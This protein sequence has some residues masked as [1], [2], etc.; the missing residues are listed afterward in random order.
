MNQKRALPVWL[1]AAALAVMC[2]LPLPAAADGTEILGPPLGVDVQPG[3][4]MV[5]AGTG[6][7]VQPGSLDFIVPG[8]AV[9]EQ[10]LLYWSGLATS[11]AGGDDTIV[12]KGQ[13]I[14]GEPVGGPSPVGASLQRT[15]YRAEIT[16][17]ALVVPGDNSLEV[18][19]LSFD[20]GNDGAGIL[21]I[22]QE[23]AGSVRIHLRDGLDLAAPGEKTPYDMSVPV[24]FSVESATF[25]RLGSLALMVGGVADVGES[26]TLQVVVGCRTISLDDPLTGTDGAMWD[27]VRVP[28]LVPAGETRILV[29]LQPGSPG[30]GEEDAASFAWVA[31]AL[32]LS[33]PGGSIG[34]LV[35][36]DRN[37]DGIEDPGEPG[38]AGVKVRLA[39]AG[40]DG[41]FDTTDDLHLVKWTDEMGH[42]RFTGLPAGS[43]EVTV[44]ESTLPAGS[45]L[46]TDN[47]PLQIELD[48]EEDYDDADFG[49]LVP[50]D[51]GCS[52][53]Y[54]KNHPGAW[55]S[56]GLTPD[57]TVESVFEEADAYPAIAAATLAEALRFHGGPEAEGGARNLLRQA[58]AA[59]LNA[60]H[61]DIAFPRTGQ[62]VVDDVNQALASGDRH[63][64]LT[65]AGELDWDNNL[66]CSLDGRLEDHDWDDRIQI[67]RAPRLRF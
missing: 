55:A 64:M 59:L 15:S 47:L 19:G 4:G 29:D 48:E 44:D 25:D 16:D 57:Q 27:T 36:N 61:A 11:E 35:W 38:L 66:G 40:E 43:C 18:G 56:T 22:Y 10:V 46:T 5:A 17:L 33:G 63:E 13:E 24:V 51:E 3:S 37:G 30:G 67:R 50:L 52:H 20:K 45:E 6:L 2:L 39:C 60:T 65:L 62:E 26:S 21:V 28:V 12:V 14:T 42:Y 49:Y 1:P 8:D 53:G 34:D 31:A 32:A 23:P 7:A 58:V 54:W 41:Q 9:V